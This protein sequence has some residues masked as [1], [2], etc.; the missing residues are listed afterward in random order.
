MKE[1]NAQD[2]VDCGGP[3]QPKECKVMSKTV[4]P[5]QLTAQRSIMAT[6]AFDSNCQLFI[7]KTQKA[8]L[9]LYS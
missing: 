1:L 8:V 9:V 5:Q 7:F 2:I 4:A 6:Q 3:L